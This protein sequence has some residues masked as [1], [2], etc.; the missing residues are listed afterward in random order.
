MLQAPESWQ[1]QPGRVEVIG[2]SHCP[3]PRRPIDQVPRPGGSICTVNV[4]K[5]NSLRQPPRGSR[6]RLPVS[7]SEIGLA[8]WTLPPHQTV[9][10][11]SSA[12]R[13]ANPAPAIARRSTR[14]QIAKTW[15]RV[16]T[17]RGYYR[18][19]DWQNGNA[20]TRS[21]PRPQ[22]NA[23]TVARVGRR[24]RIYS[25][26]MEFPRTGDHLGRD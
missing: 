14:M 24:T 2:T 20:I 17:D 7:R 4:G 5:L 3:P 15:A 10:K 6:R 8:K 16:Y 1:V 9:P 22:L 13:S 19:N 21:R 23:V 12:A 18:H 26:L 11:R 25:F